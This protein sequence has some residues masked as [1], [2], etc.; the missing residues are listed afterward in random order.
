MLYIIK[1]IF[2]LCCY[3]ILKAKTHY[4]YHGNNVS[5]VTGVG[6]NKHHMQLICY[7]I[8]QLSS[9]SGFAL[10]QNDKKVKLIIAFMKYGIWITPP[11]NGP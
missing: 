9:V 1:I 4:M 11:Y 8:L 5:T 7:R 6:V 3:D 10:A 2:Y